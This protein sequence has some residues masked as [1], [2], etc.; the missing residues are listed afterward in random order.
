MSDMLEHHEMSTNAGTDEFA[1]QE[2][3]MQ[4]HQNEDENAKTKK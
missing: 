4:Q 2:Y 3:S 1:S